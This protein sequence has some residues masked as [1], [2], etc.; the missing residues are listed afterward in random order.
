MPLLDV[1]DITVD[2]DFADTFTVTRRKETYD[3]GVLVPAV[4]ATYNN[5][6][7]VIDMAG[8][9][10][11]KRLPEGSYTGKIISIVTPFRL[12][13][14]AKNGTD[15]LMPDTI[16]WQGSDYTVIYLDPY[17]QFGSG[18]VEALAESKQAQDPPPTP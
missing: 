7:G 9:D 15:E 18:Q 13:A 12:I 14:S 1:S 17:T 16:T 4:V 11:L 8:P 10:D 5:V 2:P 6:V 3:H